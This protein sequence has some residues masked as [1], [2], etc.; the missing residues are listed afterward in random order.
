M[1]V[2]QTVQWHTVLLFGSNFTDSV[3]LNFENMVDQLL[4]AGLHPIS[5]K[6]RNLH[7]LFH[8]PNSF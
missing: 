6:T 7:I 8:T 4:T 2:K 1:R 5:N 3:K